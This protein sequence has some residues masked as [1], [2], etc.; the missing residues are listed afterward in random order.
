[1]KQAKVVDLGKGS[2]GKLLVRL[3]V[4]A[5]VAQVINML[6]NIVDRIY[7]GHIADV[8]ADAL[9][10]VGL[11]MPVIMLINAFAM[12][13]GAGGAPRAAIFMGKNEK[14][15]AEQIMGNCFTFLVVLAIGLTVVFFACAKP[16]LTLFGA[17]ENTLPYAVTYLRI[18]VC[19]SVFIMLVMGMNPFITTQ[20]FAGFSMLTTMIGAVCNIIL[21]PI[22][23]FGFK[24]G[25]AGAAYATVFSQAV[26][27]VWVLFF[28]CGKKTMLR[29]RKD[30]LKPVPSVLLPCLGLGVSTF[31]MY[32]TE[33]LL[34]VCYSSSLAKYGGDIAVGAMTI[35]TSVTQLLSM[36]VSGICQGGQPIISYNFGAKNKER[37]KQAFRCQFCACVAYTLIF[38]VLLLLFPRMFVMIF[39]NDEQLISYT[40]WATYIFMAGRFCIG[41]QNSCQQSFV[42]LGQSKI[43]LFLACLRK[44]ILMIPLIYIFPL[45]FEDKVFGV[46]LAEP[47]SDI[48]A[49]AV[50]VTMF[51]VRF[52]KIWEEESVK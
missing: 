15:H 29:I 49:A 32:S 45:F 9:T 39:N 33:S 10:G 41:F 3:A 36:P 16:M 1:M 14:D 17:S 40:V 18:Y 50:T 12:L 6:Y 48:I 5:I 42:A 47:V 35:L 31:I 22:L 4:P 38:W 27:A 28:L 19:G 23:I 24:M 2:V 20:G 21:D 52:G 26:S 30:C 37:V 25:V 43:S 13:S 11:C 8:G 7:I 44:L 34:S 51:F 46:L